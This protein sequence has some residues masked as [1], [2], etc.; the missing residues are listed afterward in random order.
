[1]LIENLIVKAHILHP[2]VGG[3]YVD[4]GTAGTRVTGY[5]VAYPVTG[6]RGPTCLGS[7]LDISKPFPPYLAPYSG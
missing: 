2:L 1:M 7:V 6:K 4:V 3:R 5:P